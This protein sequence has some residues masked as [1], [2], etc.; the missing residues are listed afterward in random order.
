[1]PGHS[2]PIDSLKTVLSQHN[3]ENAPIDHPRAER[4]TAKL[5]EGAVSRPR[6]TGTV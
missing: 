2:G 5:P 6:L 4:Q 3:Y 1:M